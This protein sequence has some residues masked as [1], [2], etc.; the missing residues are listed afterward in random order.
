L[1]FFPRYLFRFRVDHRI[2]RTQRVYRLRPTGAFGG[3]DESD[4]APFRIGVEAEDRVVRLDEEMEAIAADIRDILVEAEDRE[5]DV[6]SRGSSMSILSAIC[7]NRL[8]TARNAPA[9]NL[10]SF[11][12]RSAR[13]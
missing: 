7:S 12:G 3:F 4:D 6:I 1:L 11:A 5:I 2:H 9:E 10:R 8:A 13:H